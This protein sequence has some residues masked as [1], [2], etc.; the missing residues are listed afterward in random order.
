MHRSKVILLS[1]NYANHFSLANGY[2][3]AYAEKDPFIRDTS[4]IQ[5]LD[6]D[7][8]QHDIRQVLYYLAKEQPDIVGFSCYCWSMD[9]ILNLT[10]SLK[11]LDPKVKI[12]L[13]GPEVGPAAQKYMM[14]NPAIDAIVVGEG[15]VTFHELLRS[16]FGTGTSLAQVKGIVYREK[17]R[18]VTTETRPLYA[19]LEDIPSPYLTGIL[20]PRD[21][22]T[23]I[24]TYRGCP[25]RCAFC[26]EGKNF[27]ELRFFPEERIKKEIELIM[28]IPTIRSF[29]IVDSVFNLKKERLRKLAQ[30]FSDA[31]KFDTVLRTV[32]VMA[33]SIDEETVTLLRK[34]NVVSIETG[35]QTVNE[36]TLKIINR[37]FEKE[38][39]QRGITLLLK[40]GIEV[41][42]DLIIGLPGD[43][44]FRFAT[45]VKAM[46]H[47]NP[48]TI[49]FS[50]LHVLPG[51]DLYT[52][53]DKLGLQFDEKAPHLVLQNSTFPYDELDKAVVMAVSVGK[54]YNLKLP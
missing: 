11:Q 33:E 24:E 35:P 22:V 1:F 39:F 19:N 36:N 26:Y 5:L 2:L 37:Y 29:H 53:S 28:S 3:K 45:S 31:N 47:L 42:I 46:M 41:L 4:S 18:I 9:K 27:S 40:G 7:A 21:E 50:A 6:F 54:E 44:F 43:N 32:E 49:V 48:T 23:Y 13:G 14:E 15:E 10:R 51:T 25:Y 16:F 12:I 34:A 8:E 30:M 52:E 20:R 38:K 17:D